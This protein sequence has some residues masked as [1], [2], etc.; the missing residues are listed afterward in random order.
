MSGNC[1][2]CGGWMIKLIDG[3]CPQ[4]LLQWYDEQSFKKVRRCT[5]HGGEPEC[6]HWEE[7]SPHC[8]YYDDIPF[9]PCEFQEFYLVPVKAGCLRNDQETTT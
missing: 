7:R 3:S 5:T 4:C 8:F 6:E 2:E 9:T 1:G